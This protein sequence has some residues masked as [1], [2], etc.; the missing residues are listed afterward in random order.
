MLRISVWL[1]ANPI[2]KQPNCC[3]SC[4]QNEDDN[5]DDDDE[6]HA[7]THADRTSTID[8]EHKYVYTVF[9]VFVFLCVCVLESPMQSLSGC[10]AQHCPSNDN[11]TLSPTLFHSLTTCS[12]QSAG[13]AS[14]PRRRPAVGSSCNRTVAIDSSPDRTPQSFSGRQCHRNRPPRTAAH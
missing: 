5:D 13:H 7:I 8:T 14:R 9:C 1:A 2:S 3:E 6:D 10:H 11:R 12:F 4:A